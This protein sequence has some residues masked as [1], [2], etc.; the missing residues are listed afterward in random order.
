MPPA[1][2]CQRMSPIAASAI[3]AATRSG[4]GT[5][6]TV[7][8]RCRNARASPPRSPP[9]A[10]VAMRS[11]RAWMPRI[12]S[13]GVISSSTTRPPG[14]TTRAISAIAA[15]GSSI[16]RSPP[17]A[18]AASKRSSGNARSVQSPTS[19]RQ[20]RPV[21]W[22]FIR[23]R[24]II[25]GE[26]STPTTS[27]RGVTRSA[28]ISARSPVPVHAS[29]AAAPAHRSA[30][31]AAACRQRSPR[32][33]V[34]TRLTTSYRGAMWSNTSRSRAAVVI[35]A[36]L[37]PRRPAVPSGGT[38]HDRRRRHRGPCPPRSRPG[39]RWTPASRTCRVRPAARCPRPR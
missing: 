19:N 7:S 11:T 27:P 21:A 18:V 8:A 32:P 33:R 20:W 35:G 31:R 9:T 3:R 28:S 16:P 10:G 1:R 4:G 22:A 12:R 23:A 15:A 14:R 36:S 34:M 37:P 2:R 5:Y 13:G 25:S 39:R 38:G 24:V 30:A 29:S 6:A 26:W 17:D